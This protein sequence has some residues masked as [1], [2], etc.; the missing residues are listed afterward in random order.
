MTVL[1]VKLMTTAKNQV[2]C[3]HQNIN[4]TR[5]RNIFYNNILLHTSNSAS[6]QE[7]IEETSFSHGAPHIRMWWYLAASTFMFVHMLCYDAWEKRHSSFMTTLNHMH[8]RPKFD[9]TFVKCGMPPPISVISDLLN[10]V[11]VW[12]H[13]TVATDCLKII[14]NC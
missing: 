10:V 8:T 1:N 9:R 3:N 5:A 13:P 2:L 11:C 14:S 6:C 12:V 4:N 7:D